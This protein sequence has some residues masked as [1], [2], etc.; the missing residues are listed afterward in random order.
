MDVLR[1][2]SFDWA[3]TASG[4]TALVE[5]TAETAQRLRAKFTLFRGE[6]LH[7]PADGV[8]YRSIVFPKTVSLAA[9]IQ[10]FREI[11][12]ADPDI[13]QVVS[14]SLEPNPATP[15]AWSLRFVA[16]CKGGAVLRSEDF[17]PFV[18]GA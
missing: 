17:G 1:D 13:A 7:A 8:P 18:V 3:F 15:R 10:L 12:M 14:V 11:L 5:G 9:K 2:S 6:W 4:A 16:T